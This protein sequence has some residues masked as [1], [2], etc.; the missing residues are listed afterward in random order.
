VSAAKGLNIE[1]K[2]LR[3]GGRL[4]CYGGSKLTA[5]KGIFNLIKFCVSFGFFSPIQLLTQAKAS[6]E[7]Q[8]LS[9]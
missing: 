4:V 6:W 5:G 8:C 3:A 2:S 7:L 1:L 9:L